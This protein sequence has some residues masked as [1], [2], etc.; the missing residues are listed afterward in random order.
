M[1]TCGKRRESAQ[2]ERYKKVSVR[3]RNRVPSM[4]C[5]FSCRYTNRTL[6]AQRRR[7]DSVPRPVHFRR[8]VRRSEAAFVTV[9][10][11]LLLLRIVVIGVA[12]RSRLAS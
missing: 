4:S 5:P 10:V 7:G 12:N 6:R 3:R 1:G 11:V 9:I 8:F 2:R